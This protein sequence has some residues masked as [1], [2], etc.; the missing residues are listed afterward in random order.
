VCVWFRSACWGA[1][2]LAKGRDDLTFPVSAV[3]S[4]CDV[5]Y[6]SEIEWLGACLNLERM[7][8][9]TLRD[10]HQEPILVVAP[11]HTLAS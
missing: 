7:F 9:Q 3:C 1:S 8:T 2:A 11:S 10:E 5:L 6:S 4:L